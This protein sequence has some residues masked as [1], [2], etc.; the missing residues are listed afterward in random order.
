MNEQIHV[1]TE[2]I[3]TFCQQNHI[4]RMALFGSALR[5]D[6]DDQSDI[7]ILVEFEPGTRVGLFD[8]SRM[9]RELSIIFGRQ[10]DLLT[11]G[12]LS[13]HIRQQVTS[14]AEI[15]YEKAS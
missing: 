11:P 1:S 10:V 9:A 14:M 15:L 5:D 4:R 2:T 13:R 12:F 7:D 3:T 8:L 6:F